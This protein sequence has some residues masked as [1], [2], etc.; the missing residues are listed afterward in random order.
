VLSTAIACCYAQGFDDN[1]AL[2]H[3]VNYT[4]KYF[5]G[6]NIAMFNANH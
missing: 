2:N 3:A 4:L 6:M 1:Q 5:D